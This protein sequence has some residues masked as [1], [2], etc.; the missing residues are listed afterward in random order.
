[1]TLLRDSHER[2]FRYLRLSI[3]DVCNFRCQY[4]LPD[5]QQLERDRPSLLSVAEIRQLVQGFAGLGIEK[6]RLTGGEPTLRHDLTQIVAAVAAVPGIRE[7][8]LTTNG[9]RLPDLL[10]GLVEAG[11]TQLN[12]S[13]D[14]LTAEGFEA[15]TRSRRFD[16]VLA[17]LEQALALGLPKLKVN[18]VL[19]RQLN[20]PAFDDFLEFVRDRPLDLRFIELMQTLDNGEFFAR[21]YLAGTV[22]EA[23]LQQRGWQLQARGAT[24]GPA[25]VFAHPDYRG[26]IGLIAP[27]SADFCTSCNRL[28]VTSRGALRLCL[29]GNGSF[30]LRPWLQHPD[31][32]PLLQAEVRQALGLKT[33]GHRLAE[34]DSG[35]TRNLATFGG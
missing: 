25:R 35:D 30:D 29:F 6:V 12:L 19:L 3:T 14:H 33:S 31:Q 4:C 1:M 8:A 21:E 34:L 16:T 20:Y 32:I 10:P 28:R 23:E 17:G 22:V 5:G 9:W 27:Y 2:E 24:D 11:L 13:L 7:V 15:I 26:R 18:V